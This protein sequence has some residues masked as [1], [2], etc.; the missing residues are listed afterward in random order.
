MP[1]NTLETMNP[2]LNKEK[3]ALVTW[4]VNGLDC[5]EN[6]SHRTQTA[7]R[8]ILAYNPDVIFLQ[9]VV[10]ETYPQFCS[11]FGLNNYVTAMRP[12]EDSFYFTCAFVKSNITIVDAIRL[13]FY[14]NAASFMGRDIARLVIAVNRNIVY[15]YNCHLESMKESSAIRIAQMKQLMKLAK[16]DGPVII[17]GDLN[18]RDAEIKQASLQTPGLQLCDAYHYFGKPKECSKTWLMP[19]KPFVGCRFDRVYHNSHPRIQFA[20]M[21]L[22]GNKSTDPASDHF[23]IYTEFNVSSSF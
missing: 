4:N 18:A 2:V 13:P 23:G 9:E 12:P 7:I 8:E 15:L 11:A 10:H 6:R 20:Q 21:R 14:G 5:D 17:A 19:G 16:E 1:Q 22:I 3:F